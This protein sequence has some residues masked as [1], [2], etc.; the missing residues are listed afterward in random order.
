MNFYGT[1]NGPSNYVSVAA[2]VIG[3]LTLRGSAYEQV[4]IPQVLFTRVAR[5]E[6]SFPREKRQ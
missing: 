1:R 4:R 3:L 6:S 5:Q 2:G